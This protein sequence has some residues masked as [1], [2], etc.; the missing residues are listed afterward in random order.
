MK[1]HTGGRIAAVV[2]LVTAAALLS[3]C[4]QLLREKSEEHYE[5]TDAVQKLSVGGDAVQLEVV[6]GDGPV[7]VDETVRYNGSKPTTGHRVDDG[8]L[9]LDSPGCTGKKA[10]EVRYRVTAP[11]GTALSMDVDAGNLDATGLSGA[12]IV[13]IDVGQVTTHRSLSRSTDVRVGVGD[14]D[15]RYAGAP[16]KVAVTTNT[17]AVSLVLPGAGPYAVNTHTDVGDTDITVPRSATS[18]HAVDV[19]VDVGAIT[20]ASA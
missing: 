6:A 12:M 5:I 13:R 17:G 4:D 10:C 15:M 3:G 11:A 7:S 20:V 19:T 8:V 14:V 2:G 9:T 1:A 16:D 18:R